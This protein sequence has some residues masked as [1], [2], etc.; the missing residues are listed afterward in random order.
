MIESPGDSDIHHD[1][2]LIAATAGDLGRGEPCRAAGGLVVR[3]EF[4]FYLRSPG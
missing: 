3:P 1:R 2:K 4:V